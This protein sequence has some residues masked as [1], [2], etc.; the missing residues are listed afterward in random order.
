LDRSVQ[1]LREKLGRH[2]GCPAQ[3]V[4]LSLICRAVGAGAEEAVRSRQRHLAEQVVR[5][6][7]QHLA[8]ELL[9]RECA[10]MNRRFLEVLTGRQEKGTIYDSRGRSARGSQKGLMSV[11]L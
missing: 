7:Q 1:S 11:T 5:L 6:Q 9:V 10:R 8:T 2:L 3:E 4:C